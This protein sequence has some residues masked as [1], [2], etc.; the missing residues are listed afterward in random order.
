M[1]T[2]LLRKNIDTP[3][4][5]KNIDKQYLKILAT[6]QVAHSLEKL[7]EICRHPIYSKRNQQLYAALSEN[8]DNLQVAHFFGKPMH[9]NPVISIID[10]ALSEN[11]DNL[12]GGA[13][14]WKSTKQTLLYP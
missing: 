10:A 14:L 2:K 7:Q 9:S 8:I 3:C 13:F 12:I 6:Y 5:Q 11:I 1:S 4:N